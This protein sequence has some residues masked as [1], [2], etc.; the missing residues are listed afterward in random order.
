MT[1]PGKLLTP[2]DIATHLAVSS[3]TVYRLID[4]GALRAHKV[5][6]SYRIH[7]SDFADYMR[8]N[9]TVDGAA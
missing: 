7:P 4:C 1:L 2:R 9:F 3:M 6:R 5:G 8:G